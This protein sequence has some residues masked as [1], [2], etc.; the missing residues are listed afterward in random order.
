MHFPDFMGHVAAIYELEQPQ[1]H[2]TRDRGF[3]LELQIESPRT[4]RNDSGVVV[5]FASDASNVSAP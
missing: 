3:G 1:G 4:Q 2:Y 5:H